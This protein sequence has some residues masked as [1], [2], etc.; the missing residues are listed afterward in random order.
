MRRAVLD[1]GTN[2]VKLLV[3]DIIPPTVQPVLELSIQTRLG[4]GLAATGR[5]DPE[6]VAE[7][8]RVIREICPTAVDLSGRATVNEMVFLAWAATAALLKKQ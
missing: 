6:A 8:V 1:V 3:A 7:T 4:R 2:S 5:L